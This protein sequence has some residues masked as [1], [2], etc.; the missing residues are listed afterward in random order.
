MNW[1]EGLL[2]LNHVIWNIM[3]LFV[4]SS[5]VKDDTEEIV[6]N[7][8]CPIN[9]QVSSMLAESDVP[10]SR[11]NYEQLV[12][13]LFL[14]SDN[15]SDTLIMNVY[16]GING[17]PTIF[18]RGTAINTN[19]QLTSF[20]VYASKKRDETTDS[21]FENLKVTHDNGSYGYEKVYYWLLEYAHQFVGIAPY[22]PEGAVVTTEK[23]LPTSIAY[24]VPGAPSAQSDM[25]IATTDEFP[26]GST[27]TVSLSF[28]H[29]CSAI[30]I[31]VG[32]IPEGTVQSITFKNIPNMGTY[33]VGSETWSVESATS[34]FAVDFY[35]TSNEYSTTGTEEGNPLINDESATFMMIPQTLPDGAEMEVIFRHANTGQVETLTASLNSTVWGKGKTMNYLLSITSD[36]IL[37]FTVEE[38]ALQDAHYVMMPIT[39]KSKFLQDGWTL[40]A[41]TSDGS[42]VTFREERTVL[43]EQGYWIAD[44]RGTEELQSS[45]EG[46][47][48]TVWAFLEEN[49]GTTNR[50]IILSIKPLGNQSTKRDAETLTVQQLPVSWNGNIG[51]ER[52]EDGEYPWGFSWDN[53]M[54]I[55][56]EFEADGFWGAVYLAYINWYIKNRLNYDYVST[57]TSW[58]V[59]QS[60]TIDFSKITTTTN[61]AKSE[62]NGL[63]N[64][65]ELYNFKG[66]S[67][68]SDFMAQLEAWGGTPNKT[69]PSNP[70][71]FAARACA[72]KNKYTK[73]QVTNNG[74]TMDEAV[75]DEEDFVWYLP[76]K[77]E[78]GYLVDSEYPLSGSYWSST[79]EPSGEDEAYMF[80]VGGSTTLKPR[81]E[82]YK[83]R[84]VRKKNLS[85]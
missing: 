37:D 65:K 41:E 68:V 28:E 5:C 77:N 76:A 73:R 48:V 32:D 22:N 57:T 81:S 53:T 39:I 38:A 61:V 11:R 14:S 31:K 6:G 15:F 54:K 21:Y 45:L 35:G 47:E 3:F 56:Y 10:T 8:G 1:V 9:F 67:N 33:N 70:S 30:N 24:T 64:T 20:G 66:V 72:M 16:E 7:N 59:L 69:L 25:M 82:V 83:V 34:N 51:C 2:R 49:I 36:Y 50:E 44:D 17:N 55:T 75:L 84:A 23:G 52:I 62:V 4:F 12:Q 58:F 40:S 19:D 60:A 80:T 43:Q 27:G 42:P 71:E 29:I 74:Q 46:D 63:T 79:S 18:S 78:I 13:N 85:E 26:A